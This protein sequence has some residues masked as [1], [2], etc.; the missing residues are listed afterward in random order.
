ME[1]MLFLV[2][3]TWCHSSAHLLLAEKQQLTLTWA[4]VSVAIK[5]NISELVMGQS[6][7]ICLES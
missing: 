7:M 6:W 3:L 4:T 2:H 5:S 1:E